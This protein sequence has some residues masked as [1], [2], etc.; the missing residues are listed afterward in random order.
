MLVRMRPDD[1]HILQCRRLLYNFHNDR[2]HIALA[3]AE[4]RY[5]TAI[6]F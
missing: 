5:Q 2:I 1:R 4:K 3:K 6:N